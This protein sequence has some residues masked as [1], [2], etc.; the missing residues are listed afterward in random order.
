MGHSRPRPKAGN[1]G[2]RAH[3]NRR[4]LVCFCP[5]NNPFLLQKG[6]LTRKKRPT[7]SVPGIQLQKC[8][9]GAPGLLPP[10]AASPPGSLIRECYFMSLSLAAC[11]GPSPLFFSMYLSCSLTSFRWLYL[12][13]LQGI[14]HKHT[15]QLVT[16]AARFC[17][18]GIQ[19][20]H[21]IF[22]DAHRKYPVAILSFASFC[23]DYQFF[24]KDRKSVV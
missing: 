14:F 3:R 11:P 12:V 13:V 19:L 20:P 1:G 24:H 7:I 21:Q 8:G 10:A 5:C 6:R 2:G 15:N 9:Q 23:F 22:P 16:A 18:N 4:L 17:R